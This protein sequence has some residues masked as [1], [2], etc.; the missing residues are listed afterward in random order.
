MQP[1]RNLPVI[2]VMR[3]LLLAICSILAFT[4]CGPTK[5]LIIVPSGE[6]V[7]VDLPD[8]DASIV[9]LRGQGGSKLNVAVR[10]DEGDKQVRGFGLGARGQVEVIVESEN[11]L[12]L[13]NESNTDTKVKLFTEEGRRPAPPM[14]S[15]SVN[16]TLRNNRPTSIPLIIPSVMNPNLSPFS[17]SGVSLKYGQEILF[18][19]KGKRYVLLVVDESI[20]EGQVLDV[21]ELL[22]QRRREEGLR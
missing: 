13:I 4:A 19:E 18:R 12:V 1:L 8:Y 15:G 2:I 21:G 5:T 11:E 17:S 20:S 6:T 3:L 22:K 14:A 9:N 10:N 16:F 7:K